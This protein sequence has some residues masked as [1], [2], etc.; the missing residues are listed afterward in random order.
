[1][2]PSYSIRP[3]SIWLRSIRHAASVLVVAMLALSACATTSVG[4]AAAPQIP[5][6]AV[7]ATKVMDNGDEVTEYR[8]AGQLHV[9]KVKPL[10]GPAYYLYDRNR[11]GRPDDDNVSPVYFKLFEW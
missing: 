10:R 3:H 11:D 2:R 5:A 4:R 6:D 8:V 1:M 7:A 9:V